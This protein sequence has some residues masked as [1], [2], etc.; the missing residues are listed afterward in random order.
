MK[1]RGTLLIGTS[2]WVYEHWRGVFYPEGLPPSEWLRFYMEH[3]DTVEINNTF[4][5]LPS[6]DTF[7][8]WHRCAKRGFVYALK[9]SRY[10]T[11]MRK[12]LEPERPLSLF[13]GRAR[14]LGRNLGPLLFQLPPRWR[15]NPQRLR[16][17][18]EK[19]PGGI[20]AVFEFRE[21]SWF[22]K[23]V[24]QILE[25]R[26]MGLCLYHMP[27]FTTP[28]V[29]TAGFVYMRF[30]GSGILYGGRYEKGFLKGWASTIKGFLE[31]G[32]DVHV[33]FN[34]DALGNAVINALE[35]KELC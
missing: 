29:V 5:R 19:L 7:K 18:T 24:Y 28:V 8:S 17:F 22:S 4:Y 2:G 12:L 25:K 32:L 11:H 3:F 27:G 23:E 31:E 16:E 30:H 33:Y 26:D 20:R 6:V 21:K 9:V 1:K 15:C 34:N 35:L 14:L 10:I 13:M